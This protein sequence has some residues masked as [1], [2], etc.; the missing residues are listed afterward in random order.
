M[1]GGSVIVV[2]PIPRIER[3]ERDFCSLRQVGWLVND[4]TTALHT[5]LQSHDGSLLPHG[6]MTNLALPNPPLQRTRSSLT[7]GTTP[8]NA[9]VVGQTK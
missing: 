9:K 5:R 3:E 8:L 7:L 2:E 6:A 4:Q 1:E